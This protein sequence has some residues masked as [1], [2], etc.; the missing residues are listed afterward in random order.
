MCY[1]LVPTQTI[2]ITPKNEY[3]I[4]MAEIAKLKRERVSAKS[5]C[6]KACNRLSEAIYIDSGVDLIEAKFAT[7][8]VKWSNVQLKHDTYIIAALPEGEGDDGGIWINDLEEKFEVIE[9]AK[10]DYAREMKHK[11]QKDNQVIKHEMEERHT[12]DKLEVEGRKRTNIRDMQNKIFQQE[13]HALEILI[14]AERDGAMKVQIAEGIR[15]V[16]LQL[17]NVGKH[18]CIIWNH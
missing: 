13:V 4:I 8:K 3:G 17:D 2:S 9:K 12:V 10:F 16:K 5:L 18:T 11:L 6:T 14:K 1:Y 15:D 7:V